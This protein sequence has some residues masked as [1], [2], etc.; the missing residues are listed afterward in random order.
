MASPDA[1]QYEAE[2]FLYHEA[3]L[4]DQRHYREW[5]ELFTED[6]VYWLP[7]EEENPDTGHPTSII[8][9]DREGIAKRIKRLEHPV[10]LTEVP[11]RRARHFIS[12]VVARSLG[13][14]EIF[15]TS[16]QLVYSFRLGVQVQYPGSWE[17]TLRRVG[18]QLRICQKKVY[19]LGNDRALAQLPVL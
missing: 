7:T 17:H 10:T 1:L 3:A 19:L 2:Q 4:I 13:E 18:G 11:P 16:N 14:T 6:A 9:E 15:V 12:N 5:L 8:R